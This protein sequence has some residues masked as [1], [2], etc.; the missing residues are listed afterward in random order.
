MGPWHLCPLLITGKRIGVQ[1][2]KLTGH[3]WAQGIYKPRAPKTRPVCPLATGSKNQFPFRGSSAS[4]LV[5]GK[6]LLAPEGRY[7]GFPRV[8]RRTLQ[9]CGQNV[10][11]KPNGRHLEWG[12]PCDPEQLKTQAGHLTWHC[13]GPWH[14]A[15]KFQMATS[16][17]EAA[18]LRDQWKGQGTRAREKKRQVDLLSSHCLHLSL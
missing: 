9:Q 11:P 18:A 3:G 4:T 13:L 12:A 8:P 2:W 15:A 16:T 1:L 6:V 10:L 5:H 7:S 14:S 17:G